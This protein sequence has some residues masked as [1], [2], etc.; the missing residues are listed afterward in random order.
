MGIRE[1]LHHGKPPTN[2]MGGTGSNMVG[3][4]VAG[5]QFGDQHCVVCRWRHDD[6]IHAPAD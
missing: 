5:L 1:T 2:S 6:P 3:V 4:V